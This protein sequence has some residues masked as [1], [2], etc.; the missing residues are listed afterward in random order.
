MDWKTNCRVFV[1]AIAVA[2]IGYLTCTQIDWNH[3]PL[4]GM[5]SGNAGRS[6]TSAPD[7]SHSLATPQADSAT[8]DYNIFYNLDSDDPASEGTGALYGMVDASNRGSVDVTTRYEHYGS[9]NNETSDDDFATDQTLIQS[10]DTSSMFSSDDSELTLVD[11]IGAASGNGLATVN[12]GKPEAVTSTQQVA[13]GRGMHQTNPFMDGPLSGVRSSQQA[14]S[15]FARNQF[16]PDQVTQNQFPIDGSTASRFNSMQVGGIDNDLNS[17]PRAVE[18]GADFGASSSLAP[19]S[20]ITPRGYRLPDSIAQKAA[21]HIEYGKSLARRGASQSA[22]Q[23]FYH[24]LR[25]IAQA[26]DAGSG[27][28]HHTAAL[29]RA[30]TTLRE[31]SEFHVGDSETQMVD[32]IAPIVDAHTSNV[33]SM[34]RAAGMTSIEALQQ[35]YAAAQH[36]FEIAAGRN[37]VS[38]EALYCLGKLHS[39]MSQH[40]TSAE[41]LGVAKSILYHRTAVTCDQRNYRSANELGAMLARNGQADEAI[42]L[43]KQSLRVKQTSQAWNNLATVHQRLGQSELAMRAGGEAERMANLGGFLSVQSGVEWLDAAQFNARAPKGFQ[44]ET[45]ARVPMPALPDEPR[46]SRAPEKESFMN[47]INPFR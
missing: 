45:M 21:H 27:N 8:A 2:G 40:E 44:N 39:S 25:L 5:T 38:G 23:E 42:G 14:P 37:V 31:A 20:A 13:V 1:G 41:P 34:E 10:P 18:I 6:Q 15:Q 4:T 33:I 43:F 3:S 35:Y 17:L 46:V 16:A 28:T 11:E 26:S 7:E 47:R 9:L 19:S 24:G 32:N 36:N 29:K 30:I 22:R 12:T